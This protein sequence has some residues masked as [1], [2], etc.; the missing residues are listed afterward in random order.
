M[1]QMPNQLQQVPG[2][3][4]DLPNLLQ[5]QSPRMLGSKKPTEEYTVSEVT[6][7]DL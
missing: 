6:A 3:A 1:Q 2:L 4:D 5:A 7:M